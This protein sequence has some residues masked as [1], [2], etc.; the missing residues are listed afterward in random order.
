MNTK[1]GAPGAA[2]TGCGHAGFD[3]SVVRPMIPGKAVP[4]LYSSSDIYP[5]SVLRIGL[6]AGPIPRMNACGAT[7]PTSGAAVA[8]AEIIATAQ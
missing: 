3:T 5:P 7:V 2:R 1:F 8:R 6:D 4:R